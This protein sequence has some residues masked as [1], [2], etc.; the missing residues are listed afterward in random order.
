LEIGAR[1]VLV[2]GTH[3]L[4]TPEVVNRLYSADGAER[5]WGWPRLPGEYHGSGCT[6]ASTVAACLALGYSMVEAVAA[7][8]EYTWTTLDQA[9]RTGRGQLTPNRMFALQIDQ[10][11]G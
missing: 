9:L 10:A 6:L 4:T 7:A 8:Q 11:T 2:T 5:T 1:W 3:D